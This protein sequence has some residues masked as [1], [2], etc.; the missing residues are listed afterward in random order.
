MTF[1]Q[2]VAAG[3]GVAQVDGDA[4]TH[5]ITVGNNSTVNLGTDHTG[6]ATDHASNIKVAGDTTGIVTVNHVNDGSTTVQMFTSGLEVTGVKVNVASAS[7]L[8]QAEAL[9]IT[10]ASNGGDSTHN[11][12]GVFNWTDGN[13]YI[14]C[15]A[16]AAETSVSTSD[17]VV[18]LTGLHT[19]AF[20]LAGHLLLA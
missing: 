5:V 3:V 2:G 1:K 12:Y 14:V 18:E 17:V 11:Y 19:A 10:V 6:A 15:H 9:A 7:T 16:G 8:A 4:G 13:T 20:T